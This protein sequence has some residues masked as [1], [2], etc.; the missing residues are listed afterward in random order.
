M[1]VFFGLDVGSSQI[2]VLQAE[3]SSQGFKLVNYS[4]VDL[5]ASE[6]KTETIKRALHLAKIKP[7]TEVNLALPEADV[8]TRI[9]ETPRLSEAE[10]ASSIRYEA[11]EYIPVPLDEVEL[12]H[13]IVSDP[14]ELVG[15]KTMRVLLIAVPKERIKLLTELM[16]EVGLIP[17][18]LETELFSLKRIFSSPKKY[19][20]LALFSHKTTDLMILDKGLP[21]FMHSLPSGGLALTKTLASELALAEDQ[22]EQYK[23]TYGLQ[24]ELLE[25][26]VAGVLAPAIDEVINQ[27]NKALVYLQ[28]QGQSRTPEQLVIAGGGAMLPGLSGY[29]VKKMNIEVVVG[30]PLER[31]IKDEKFKQIITSEVNPHLAIVTSLAVKDWL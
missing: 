10:L 20:I 8:Y 15:A 2:K 29:L 3:K 23:R 30:D 14:E 25:G 13:Q 7:G 24:A 22:A 12:H 26:K 1:S 28:Q 19:Q 4:A 6:E 5:S 27:I 18:T 17:K 31:F 11:E 9:I 16:D 21:R